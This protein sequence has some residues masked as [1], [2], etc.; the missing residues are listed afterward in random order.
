MADGKVLARQEVGSKIDPQSYT[1]SWVEWSY[2]FVIPEFKKKKKSV[3]N[4]F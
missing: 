3:R 1:K 4:L 2:A